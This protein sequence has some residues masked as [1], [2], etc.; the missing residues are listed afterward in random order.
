M[1][2][3]Y[4]FPFRATAY[5]I[6]NK[7]TIPL[8]S[9][10]SEGKLD[11]STTS[12]LKQNISEYLVEYRMIND[13][14]E[15]TDGKIYNL[16]C[17]FSLYID[18]NIPSNQIALNALNTIIEYF[19]I[20]NLQMNQ[21]IYLGQLIEK[22]NNVNG[23]LNV[24]DYTFYNKI[25]SGYSTNQIPMTIDPFN[26]QISLIN[27]SLYSSADGMFEIKNPKTDIRLLLK[28]KNQL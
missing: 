4:G 14:V 25:G 15:I 6:N 20:Y 22:I 8:I 9:I 17:D 1:P 27:N 3:R 10:D 7:V 5:K 26:G 18:E 28:K 13:Y 11:N 2:S 24:L 19:N 16:A 21:D 12:L 23:V